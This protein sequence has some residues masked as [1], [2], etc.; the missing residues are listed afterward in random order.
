[1]RWYKIVLSGGQT[2]DATGDPNALNV[3]LDI[4]VAAENAPKAGAYVQIWGIPLSTLLNASQYNNQDIS[5][6]G[7]MQQGLPL[8]NPNQQG[9]LCRGK[10]LP[11]LG[12][13]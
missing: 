1:M 5:V 8:A 13:W 9:L 7:G 3:K 12:N 10:I 4:P 2:W 11:A 6:Y